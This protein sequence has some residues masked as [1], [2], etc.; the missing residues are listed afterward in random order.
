VEPQGT[1][2]G[3]GR[4]Q[5]TLVERLLSPIADVRQDEAASALLMALR[6]GGGGAKA[7]SRFTGRIARLTVG[8]KQHRAA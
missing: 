4:R 5:K 2:A 3:G 6:P 8:G 7:K 1:P